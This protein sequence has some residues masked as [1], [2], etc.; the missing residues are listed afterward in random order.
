LNRG[1]ISE[2]SWTLFDKYWIFSIGPLIYGCFPNG[3]CPRH[4]GAWRLTTHAQWAAGTV[5]QRRFDYVQLLRQV[6]AITELVQLDG[7]GKEQLKVSRLAMDVVGGGT[8][9]AQNPKFKEALAQ[10]I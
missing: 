10:K 4:C 9:Y 8:D 7:E 2:K 6:P 1:A 3:S 5:E